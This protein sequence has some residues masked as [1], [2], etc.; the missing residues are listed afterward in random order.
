MTLGVIGLG[1]IGGSM[2]LELKKN[3]FTDCVIGFDKSLK[4]SQQALELGI[5][6]EHADLD[7]LMGRS[8]II[9]L[10][11][12]V[13]A[14]QKLLPT[15]L[16]HLTHKQ[17]I[18]DV[19]S[20]KSGICECVSSHKNRS[21]FVAT[22]PMAGTEFSG[23]KAATLGLFRDKVA[24]I[25]DHRDSSPLAVDKVKKL[26]KQLGMQVIFMDSHPHDMHAAYVSHISHISSFVL[27]LAVLD[28]EKSEKTLLDMASGGFDSTVRLA[29]SDA[30]MW[31]EIFIQNKDCI[32]EVLEAYQKN[33]DAF[34]N[35]ISAQDEKGI[36]DLI[37][38]ANQ[39]KKALK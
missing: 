1:L 31:S 34:K 9:I 22:H 27:A 8:D 5:I 15:L 3:G 30:N 26:Y 35:S 28:K 14:A 2:S 18:L 37:I 17:I 20:T 21:R 13:I 29:K 25:C 23:P 38:K 11:V 24:I 19:G 7:E 36:R 10:S 4:H 33:L 32:L 6:D 16:D 39:I 12:P